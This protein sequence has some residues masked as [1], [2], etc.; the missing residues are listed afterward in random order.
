[1]RTLGEQQT[2]D[3]QNVTWYEGTGEAT[4][5]PAHH[6]HLVTFGSSFNVT[7]RSQALQETQRILIP[8]GW[9]ACLWNHRDL[10]DP[11]QAG[12]E[13]LIRAQIPNYS[14]GTRRE[15]QR[16]FLEQS[17]YFEAVFELSGRVVHQQSLAD[18]LTAWRSH[19]TL[20]RQAGERFEAILSA[21][22]TYLQEKAPAGLRIPYTT[23]IWFGRFRH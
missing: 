10:Q 15:D 16:E 22:E 17:G 19:A 1:M 12:I 21:I 5:R 2:R 7:D 20:A 8:G 9:F 14:Y 3:F 18:C 6:Y 11:L 13:A 23:R 4:G